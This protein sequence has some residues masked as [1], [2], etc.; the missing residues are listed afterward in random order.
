MAI[1]VKT[2]ICQGETGDSNENS[3][4]FDREQRVS[5]VP[6]ILCY[7]K[8]PKMIIDRFDPD[9]V[10]ELCLSAESIATPTLPIGL[11]QRSIRLY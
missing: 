7:F 9:P 3:I 1:W 4:A 11:R 5:I 6:Q 2:L 10:C 8:V